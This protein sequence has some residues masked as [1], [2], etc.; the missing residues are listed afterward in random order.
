MC[1]LGQNVSALNFQGHYN[2]KKR[3][4][5][6][7]VLTLTSVKVHFSIWVLYRVDTGEKGK[8]KTRRKQLDGGAI[9][10][11]YYCKTTSNQLEPAQKISV[12]ANC[13]V[14]L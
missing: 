5:V 12:T 8:G 4:Q 11:L 3:A 14:L 2:L 6:S 7:L 13:P 10:E 9:K 1:N